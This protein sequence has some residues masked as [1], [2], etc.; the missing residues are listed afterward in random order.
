MESCRLYAGHRT[1]LGKILLVR[2]NSNSID[3]PQ[4]I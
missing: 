1:Q 2:T 3:Q 4:R